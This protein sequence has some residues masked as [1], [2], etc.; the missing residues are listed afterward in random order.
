MEVL[1]LLIPAA[2][3]M[4][5]LFLGLFIWAVKSKQYE[6]LRGS[7]ERLLVDDDDSARRP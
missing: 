3:L 1:M 7:A 4:A 2:L 5:A 6:D